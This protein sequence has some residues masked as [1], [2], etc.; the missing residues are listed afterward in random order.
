MHLAASNSPVTVAWAAY[1][2]AELKRHGLYVQHAA[3][4]D[5]PAARDDRLRACE[6][7][8]SLWARWRDLYLGGE[9]PRPAA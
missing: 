9:P 6:E 5:T 1:D 7:A 2:A 8:A 4:A 3:L